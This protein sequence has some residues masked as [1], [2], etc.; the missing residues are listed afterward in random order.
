MIVKDTL[1]VKILSIRDKIFPFIYSPK[2]KL[3]FGHVDFVIG[4]G[5]LPYYYQEFIISSLNVPLFFVRGNHD[6]V[7][8]YSENQ[9]YTHPLGGIN[10]HRKVLRHQG[11]TITGIE[12][13]IRY[14]REGEFQYTQRQM[15]GH[16]ISLIPG[17]LFY[18]AQ[19]GRFLDIFV[20]H[21]PPLG[22]HDKD[23]LPHQG[24][25]A[26]RWFLEVFQPKYHFHG[27]IHVYRPDTVC[28]TLFRNTKVINT[29]GCLE[30]E[31]EQ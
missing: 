12:G 14:K 11:L 4:C 8:E 15:W 9:S 22:I 28:E 26:F 30:T 18:R 23:D 16:I 19:T 13:S 1:F 3:K 24:V 5:D 25:K 2:V 31:I 7:T 21:A 20:T 10:L 6:P 27:H 17:L 29:Y